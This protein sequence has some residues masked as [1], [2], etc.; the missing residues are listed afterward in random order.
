MFTTMLTGPRINTSEVTPSCGLFLTVEDKN[1][2][3]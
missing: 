3:Y 2:Q 1:M